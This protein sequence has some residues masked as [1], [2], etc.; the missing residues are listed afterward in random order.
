MTS[1]GRGRDG[2]DRVVVR[3]QR[4]GNRLFEVVL[5][6]LLI[7]AGG[8]IALPAEREQV[9]EALVNDWL[10]SMVAGDADRAWSLMHPVT[11]SQVYHDSQADFANDVA[12]AQWVGLIWQVQPASFNDGHYL[13]ELSV[14][15]GLGSVP[16]FLLNRGLIDTTVAGDHPN[17]PYVGV[18]IDGSG[19]GILSNG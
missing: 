5:F 6:L 17:V 14:P 4:V 1:I 3:S 8:C 19:V 11:Q 12:T 9:A 15:T 10:S 13:V 18:R 16:Q 2:S 7:V